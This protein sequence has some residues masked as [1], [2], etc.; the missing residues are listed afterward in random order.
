ML[1]LAR[2]SWLVFG[3]C[4]VL[5]GTTWSQDNEAPTKPAA[6]KPAAVKGKLP[7]YFA[8]I[9]LSKV[10]EDEIRKIAQPFDEKI[11]GLREQ[12]VALE[13]K[14]REQEFAK[15]SACEVKLAPANVT[16]LKER[17]ARAEAEKAAAAK[18]K[19]ES[20]STDAPAPPTKPA[21]ATNT[22]PAKP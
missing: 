21:A 17:R 7:N 6:G 9:G 22:K 14:I 13:E 16:A 11:S 4:L 3:V 12:I 1:R 8:Q 18:K 10:Q 19:A 15:L 20:T 5:Q 2:G